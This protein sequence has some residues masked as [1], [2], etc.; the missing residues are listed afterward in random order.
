MSH[1]SAATTVAAALPE[2]FDNPFGD[3]SMYADRAVAF[4][5]VASATSVVY[6][7]DLNVV[8]RPEAQVYTDPYAQVGSESV[9]YAAQP[10]TLHPQVSVRES[11]AAMHDVESITTR[12][13]HILSRPKLLLN[14]LV[15]WINS[16]AC[17]GLPQHNR[18]VCRVLTDLRHFVDESKSDANKETMLRAI[19][20]ALR[21]V[22][23]NLARLDYDTTVPIINVYNAL[24]SEVLRDYMMSRRILSPDPHVSDMATVWAE[25]IAAADPTLPFGLPKISDPSRLLDAMLWSQRV[26]PPTLQ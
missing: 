4:G 20:D 23:A 16:L 2:S 5:D 17:H 6:E 13:T 7:A 15:F 3:A 10:Y 24:G 18:T 14:V 11:E 8:D 26:T 12:K 25:V 19:D 21:E 22:N 1:A 9:S